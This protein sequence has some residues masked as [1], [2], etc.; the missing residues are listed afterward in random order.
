M[1]PL[2]TGLEPTSIISNL[3]L[4][5]NISDGPTPSVCCFVFQDT[6]TEVWARLFTTSTYYNVVNVTSYT[7]RVTPGPETT[8]TN[9]ETNIFT[10][11]ATF[12]EPVEVG[13]N[14][15]TLFNNVAPRPSQTEFSYNSSQLITHGITV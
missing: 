5:S 2:L 7:V 3:T 4:T 8:E 15:I 13:G 14:P 10:T 6:V 9:I 11:N 12:M 1:K